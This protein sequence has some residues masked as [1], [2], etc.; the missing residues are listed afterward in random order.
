MDRQAMAVL[1]AICVFSLETEEEPVLHNQF[2][3][4]D[5]GQN[6]LESFGDRLD[7]IIKILSADGYLED[8]QEDAGPIQSVLPVLK[9]A[10]LCWASICSIRCY[11]VRFAESPTISL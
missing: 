6:M 9:S 4:S 8:L 11:I 7:T 5:R 1:R 3:E 2:K 10:P